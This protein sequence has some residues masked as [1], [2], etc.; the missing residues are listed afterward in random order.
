[1]SNLIRGGQGLALGAI[2]YLSY[3]V[4]SEKWSNPGLIAISVALAIT[5]WPFAVLSNTIDSALSRAIGSALAGRAGRVLFQWIVNVGLIALLVAISVA[6]LH[7]L[8]R[9]GGLVLSALVV[10]VA[11]QG[12]QYIGEWLSGRGIGSSTGNVVVA[13][14]LSLMLNALAVSGHP[15]AQVLTVSFS[16]L[17]TLVMLCV[18][19]T[20]NRSASGSRPRDAQLR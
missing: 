14:T 5:T 15:K 16:I 9:M 8:A 6:N 19:L 11:S 10:T 17:C 7:E 18:E 2:F 20:A 13:L 1:V 3:A 4:A 12:F